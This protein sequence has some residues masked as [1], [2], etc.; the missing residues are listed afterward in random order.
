M[1]HQIRLSPPIWELL[2]RSAEPFVDKEPEDTIRRILDFYLK[3]RGADGAASAPSIAAPTQH[4]GPR[5]S[6]Q[7]GL[8]YDLDGQHHDAVSVRDFYEQVLRCLVDNHESKLTRLVPFRTSSER[9]LVARTPVHPSGNEFVIPVT[10]RG[11]HMEA[12]KDY[13]NAIAHAAHLA[14]RMGVELR[15]RN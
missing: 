2:K 5:V 1:T 14:D 11:Y 10:Y 6:R 12:H 9:Y 13:K 4:A 7:R 15:F 8:S 3:N